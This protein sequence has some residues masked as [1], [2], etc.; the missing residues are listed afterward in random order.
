MLRLLI[1]LF[2]TVTAAMTMALYLA[3]AQALAT[4]QLLLLLELFG[5]DF[6]FH[7]VLA[8]LLLLARCTRHEV[9]FTDTRASW[10]GLGCSGRS[11]QICRTEASSKGVW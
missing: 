8:D 2:D 3:L 11:W 6:S 4:L 10:P 5:L 7:G 9:L 1:F